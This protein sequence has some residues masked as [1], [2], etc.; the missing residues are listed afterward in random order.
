MTE[1]NNLSLDE[2]IHLVT[3]VG[4]WKTY[5]ANG[6]LST[7]TMSDGPHG[8][9]KQEEENY[10]DLNHS[11]IATCF[12][13]GS[14]IASSFDTDCAKKLATAL[15]AEAKAEKVSVVLGPAINIKRSPLCGRN[16][17]YYSEDP[18]LA[19]E[20][21]TA[22]VESME[23]EGVGTSLKH[24]AANN[25]ENHRMTQ[26]SLVDKRALEEI[27]LAAF[28]KCII[29]AKPSTVM[30]SYNKINGSYSCAN[31]DLLIKHL[32]NE[33]KYDGLVVSDWGAAIGIVDCI[34][35]GLDLEMPDSVGTHTQE[36]KEAISAG[37]LTEEELDRAVKNVIKLS[38]RYPTPSKSIPADYEAHHKLAT[39]LAT[40]CAVLLKHSDVLPLNKSDKVLIIGD[41]A[42][43][44]R[45][46]GGGSSHITT[47]PCKN[48]VDALRVKGFNIEYSNVVPD[49][50][51][52][53]NKVLY[54][55]GLTDSFESE[56]YDRDSLN[57]PLH[58]SQDLEQLIN[59]CKDT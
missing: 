35:S 26:D 43:N 48:V 31:N 54:F 10:A 16:F 38:E 22:Y 18:Y 20:M 2:K 5:D 50:V 33:W 19:G 3:G 17:E 28:R 52:A 37:I 29:S 46:Q 32:R 25:Q 40:Q 56:G 57:I 34:K 45:F 51:K 14:A 11:N 1:I 44:M 27:Y 41:M 55:G 15:A 21:A 53:Y 8:L 7:V 42:I 6:K 23:N 49:S 9:R 58:Q 24:F 13:T 4:S 36:L 12:P 30:A 47:L 59:L 39:E